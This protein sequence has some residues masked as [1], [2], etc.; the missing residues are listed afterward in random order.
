[1]AIHDVTVFQWTSIWL[2]YIIIT[3]RTVIFQESSIWRLYKIVHLCR[4]PNDRRHNVLWASSL[5]NDKRQG[6]SFTYRIGNSNQFFCPWLLLKVAWYIPNH[7][8]LWY[9]RPAGIGDLE[10]NTNLVFRNKAMTSKRLL[11]LLTVLIKASAPH[12]S[13][14]ASA[15]YMYIYKNQYTHNYD[16]YRCVTY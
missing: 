7:A 4:M 16:I 14:K 8:S 5:G 1:M 10:R 3:F 2:L 6:L 11:D 13:I 15:P 9:D 12:I